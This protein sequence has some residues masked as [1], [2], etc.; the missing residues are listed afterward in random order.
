[1]KDMIRAENLRKEY[2]T[3]NQTCVAVKDISI[4][5]K[6]ATA[7]AIIGPSGCGKSTLLQML[8]GLT[9][10]TQGKIWICGED[11]ELLNEKRK[12][13]LRNSYISY[14]LQNFA[15]VEDETVKSNLE[16]PML[17]EKPVCKKA[18]RERRIKEVLERVGLLEK[19]R[20][21]VCNL[22]GGQQQRIAIARALIQRAEVML[23]DEPTGALNHQMGM[24]IME[25]LL[26][27]VREQKKALV[28]VT[29]NLELAQMCDIIYEM[30]D[31]EF[32]VKEGTV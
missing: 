16:L 19:E 1:M 2:C 7:I 22:S 29:H 6:P 14:V 32:C 30:S 21:L 20:E 28:L 17:L 10:P 4:Q 11:V 18:E 3:G 27:L 12:A 25:L 9:K 8:G 23:A 24:E 13:K 5:V 31:G 26:E 15:L